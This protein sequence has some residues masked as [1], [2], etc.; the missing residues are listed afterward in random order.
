[1]KQRKQQVNWRL[2][3][4]ARELARLIAKDMGD[5]SQGN[6]LEIILREEAARRGITLPKESK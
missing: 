1:V 4:A 6:A 2:S 5:L 3:D